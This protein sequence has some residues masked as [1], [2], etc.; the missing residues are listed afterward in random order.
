M[1]KAEIA[2][3]IFTWTLVLVVVGLIGVFGVKAIQDFIQKQCLMDKQYFRT[4]FARIIYETRDVGEAKAFDDKLPCGVTAI[5]FYDPTK[6]GMGGDPKYQ[7][8]FIKELSAS[9]N[10]F[11]IKSVQPVTRTNVEAFNISTISLN[12][13]YL[14]VLSESGLVN[15]KITGAG[16]RGTAIS[17]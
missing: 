11:L 10:V 6:A 2:S 16:R 14:C 1:K 7:A 13:A 4:D 3:Q 8:P 17:T 12:S 5:C 15:L 9:N